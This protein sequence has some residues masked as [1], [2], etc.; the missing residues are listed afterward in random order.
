M[1]EIL[2]VQDVA[3]MLQ[4]SE[5]TVRTLTATKQLPSHKIGSL[6]RYNRS[7]IMSLMGG[8]FQSDVILDWL[9]KQIEIR[10]TM[11]GQNNGIC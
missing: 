5:Q 11:G 4:M 8:E 2:T 1:N 9:I 6:V 3:K 7:E 10:K